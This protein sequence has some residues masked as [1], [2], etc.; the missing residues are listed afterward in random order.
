MTDEIAEALFEAGCEDGLPSSSEGLAQVYFA[1]EAESLESA[2]SCA[3]SEIERAGF[4]FSKVEIDPESLHSLF[5]N[6]A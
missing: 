4:E 3:L 6:V 1:R 5:R 2:I